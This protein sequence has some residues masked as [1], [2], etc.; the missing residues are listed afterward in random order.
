MVALLPGASLPRMGA[1]V[2]G[3]FLLLVGPLLEAFCLPR[4]VKFNL[5]RGAPLPIMYDGGGGAGVEC[6]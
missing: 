2:R 4:V 5:R 1:I 3:A 6:A